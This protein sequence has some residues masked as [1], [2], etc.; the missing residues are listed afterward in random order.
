MLAAA[1]LA[2]SAPLSAHAA[3]AAATS[4]QQQSERLWLGSAWYPEQWPEERWA[5]DLRLM[6]AHGANVVRIG[7]FAWSRMETAEGAYDMGWLVRATRLAAKYGISVVVGTPTDTPPAWMTQRYPDVLRVDGD[8]RRLGHGGRRQFSISSTR[9]RQLS[10]A[11]VAKMAE[12]LGQEPNVIGWQIG[13]EYTDESYDPDART[14]WVAWLKQRYGTLD[15]LNDAWTTAY[16]SQT[17]G[18]WEQV[19][20]NTEKGNPGLMLEQKRF[21][22]SQWIAFQ[23]N[24]LDAIRATASPR[25]FIT[26]NLGGLGWANRFD[27][28]A[29]NRD[30]DFASWDN[31]V[32][33]GHLQPYRNGATH[34][35]VRG[36]KRKNFWVMEIQPGFV[37]W[38]PVSNML[39]PGETRAMAWQAIGHGADGILYWQ[40]RNALNGQET[41]HGSIL[42][43]DGTPLPVY[44]EVTQIGRDMAKASTAVA[45]TQPV[46]PVAI[47][48][49]YP[50]RWAI[51]FQLHHKDYDQIEVLLDYYRPL[52]DALGAV[53]I[54][55]A[56]AAPLAGY[57]LVVAP[58]LNVITDDMAARLAAYVRGG[59]HLILGPRSGMKDGFNRL[60]V[61]RQP[62]PLADL[63]GGRVEQ[64]YALDEQVAVDGGTASIWAEDLSTAAPDTQV[65]LRYGKANGW[66]DGHPAAITRAVGKGRITYVGAL[67]DDAV[68]KGLI[69]R[70][71]ADAGIAREFAI[72]ADVELMTRT[73]KDRE[74][75]ILINHGREP[76]DVALP[77]AMTDIL[78]GGRKTALTLAPEGVAVLE[79]KAR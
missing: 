40:W 69:D 64:F 20:F 48:Q 11:V 9:Y 27:R 4:A 13:N 55:E 33:T 28:Y 54:V 26:T 67:F 65:L 39:S 17:Y 18:G 50:S 58:S 44:P 8:G 32:G 22:T 62:G 43:P 30:L 14:A 45:G 51:D 16:W 31:Y 24:Q 53:D 23:K 75:V 19:P 6:K 72:P 37:N 61:Q 60:A 68:M 34:D 38:A 49:D 21:I 52:K 10:R 36:W 79:R 41:M 59:G 42:G 70:A 57:K 66:L 46:S 1:A 5:E 77:G 35:L 78:A 29:I 25:Q 56:A 76:R 74:I 15:K 71:M 73:G 47:L 12:A 2:L 63:L 3:P 7:E